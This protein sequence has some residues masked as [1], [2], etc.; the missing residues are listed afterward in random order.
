MV[1]S[2]QSDRGI[3]SAVDVIAQ[4]THAVGSVVIAGVVTVERVQAGCRVKKSALVVAQ[5]AYACC[6]VVVSNAIR[7]HGLTA[8]RGI[9]V[10]CSIGMESGKSDG[11]IIRSSI[12][13]KRIRTHSRVI[14]GS[15]VAL[16]C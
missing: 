10:A 11:G 15:P 8:D 14:I 6:G 4:S 16:Q 13:E 2:I 12:R 7:D 3:V 9:Q 1:K 5:R